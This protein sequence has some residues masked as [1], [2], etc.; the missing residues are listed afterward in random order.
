MLGHIEQESSE[1]YLETI[2]QLGKKSKNLRA[3]DISKHLMLSRSSVSRA[4]HILEAEGF[5][6]IDE[7]GYIF[8]TSDGYKKASL[9]WKKHSLLVKLFIIVGRV[10]VEVADIDACRVEHVISDE[11]VTAIKDFLSKIGETTDE[12]N[13]QLL[14]NTYSHFPNGKPL[15]ESLENYL[16]AIL[17]LS[18]EFKN[19]LRAINIAKHLSI[20]R[21]SVSRA[22]GIMV[23]EGLITI[24]K[25]GFIAL[26]EQGETLAKKIYKRHLDLSKFFIQY[27]KVSDE[28]AKKDA[29]RI[30]HLIS[31][32]LIIGIREFMNNYQAN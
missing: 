8:L 24:D 11:T 14:E 21:A 4:I 3:I 9:I 26:N 29:C 17:I 22:I 30:E 23:S 1:N 25:N 13:V 16:E 32:D 10:S 27:L 19:K 12:L 31:E 28:V 5:I 7:N 20:S 6:E 18:T 15:K 2:F